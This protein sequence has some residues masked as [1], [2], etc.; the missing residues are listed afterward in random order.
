MGSL[1]SSSVKSVHIEF[2]GRKYI[3]KIEIKD[4]ELIN[5]NIYLDNKLKYKGNIC[6][7]KIKIKI[8]EFLYYNISEIFEEINKLNNNN[9]II[10]K[11]NNKY[12]LKIKFIILRRENYLYINLNENIIK[13]KDNIIL[14]QK[15]NNKNDNLN[16][17]NNLNDYNISLKN[18]IHTLNYHTHWI[19]CLSVLNDGRLISGSSDF[20]IIIYNKTTYK[21]DII[22]KEHKNI[23]LY[24]TQLS[25]G[26]IASCSFDKTIKL[27]NIKRNNYNILQ[28][29]NDH[30]SSVYKIIEL[31]NKYLVSCSTDKSIIFYLKDNNK[32]KKE[33]HIST[34]GP[35][36]C[37]NEIKENEI[38]YSEQI[39]YDPNNNN[40]CFYNINERKIKSSISNISKID[41]SPFIMISKELLFIPGKNK[42]SLIDINYYELIR[43]IKVPDSDWIYGACMLNE[44]IILTGDGKSTIREWKI[45][46][47]NLILISKKEKAHNN[48]ILTL[49]NIGNG[50]IASGSYDKLIKIW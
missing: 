33:Y 6:L 47:D 40:I 4:E 36:L 15:L 30:T 25:S 7:Q 9:F 1:N 42:I 2:E 26:I 19:F 50:Y 41:I 31:K 23:V 12:K 39:N 45:E 44:N 22:I 43:E 29:L 16:N 46:G 35:C 20:S 8:K 21:P 17:N 28:T 49:L 32:Y 11:E 37:I 18:P 34:N 13:E 3:C 38:C 5:I 48:W 24:I 27:F 14:E 10:I